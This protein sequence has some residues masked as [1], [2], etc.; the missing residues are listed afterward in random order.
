MLKDQNHAREILVKDIEIAKLR[1]KVVSLEKRINQRRIQLEQST[2]SGSTTVILNKELETDARVM[3]FVEEKVD[4][5][6]KAERQRTKPLLAIGIAVRNGYL[7]LHKP[8]TTNINIDIIRK[9]Y[10]AVYAARP[11]A[12]ACL[13]RDSIRIDIATYKY[14][15]GVEYS[16]MLGCTSQICINLL[17]WYAEIKALNPN[18]FEKTAFYN[19][20][21]MNA[22]QSFWTLNGAQYYRDFTLDDIEYVNKLRRIVVQEVYKEYEFI[23]DSLAKDKRSKSSDFLP[24]RGKK[25]AHS[26]HLV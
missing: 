16:S 4:E 17:A 24:L 11:L 26:D 10:D 15:Y 25:A 21:C 23:I 14:I 3:D 9:F 22:F 6:L 18:D 1:L 7:E 12:D 19:V 8:T 2:V 5:A 20:W 13:Y